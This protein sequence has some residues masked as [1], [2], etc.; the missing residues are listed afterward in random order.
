[1]QNET[2]E[3][4]IW[5]ATIKEQFVR[6]NFQIKVPQVRV[7]DADGNQV[8][9]METKKALRAAEE[10][11]LDLVE[12]SPGA[13]PPVCK[14][15]D[16][17]KFKYEQQKKVREGRKKQHVIHLKEIRL[18]PNIEPHDFDFKVRNARKFLE[19]GDKVK[20]SIF[21]QGREI[22]HMELG[23]KVL[24]R[25]EESLQ[26]IAKLESSPKKENRQII[27]IFVKK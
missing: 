14:I 18:R 13:S 22:V 15:I 5:R 17:G 7:I 6:V 8:G 4:K 24:R 20:A 3:I 12:I 1:M 9:I 10:V 11:G 27:A 19:Q 16:Y 2:P 26:D 25:M 21:F 23:E